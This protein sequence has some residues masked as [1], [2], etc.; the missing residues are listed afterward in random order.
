MTLVKSSSGRCSRYRASSCTFESCS[1]DADVEFG[2]V[3]W[4]NVEVEWLMFAKLASS[5]ESLRWNVAYK[6]KRMFQANREKPV[7]IL[8]E[9]Q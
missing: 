3:H 6:S 1:D 9:D 4:E 8:F 7:H 5:W 2:L